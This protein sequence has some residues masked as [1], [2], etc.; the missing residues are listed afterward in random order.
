MHGALPCTVVPHNI[1]LTQLWYLVWVLTRVKVQRNEQSSCSR[2]V[3]WTQ[4]PPKEFTLGWV[5]GMKNQGEAHWCGTNFPSKLGGFHSRKYIFYFENLNVQKYDP[6]FFGLGPRHVNPP[7]V[8]MSMWY[9]PRIGWSN[10]PNSDEL[11]KIYMCV[12]V[13]DFYIL[14][15]K[16]SFGVFVCTF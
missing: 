15:F 8:N 1:T 12:F 7:L 5:Q 9:R 3:V 13:I 6:N 4:G 16:D 10:N 14:S 11:F 2:E